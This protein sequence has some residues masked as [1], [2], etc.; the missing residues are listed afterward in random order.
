MLESTKTRQQPTVAC[1]G[2]SVQRRAVLRLA[3]CHE[4]ALKPEYSGYS[5]PEATLK[6]HLNADKSCPLSTN[7]YPPNYSHA[8]D[9]APM[10]RGHKTPVHHSQSQPCR[11]TNRGSPLPHRHR[12]H[13][14]RHALRYNTMVLPPP[15]FCIKAFTKLGGLVNKGEKPILRLLTS[16]KFVR[17]QYKAGTC[18][19]TDCKKA[20]A[21]SSLS[22]SQISS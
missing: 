15:I 2:K 8:G 11:P 3:A 4:P 14:A 10:D 6:K 20:I 19:G 1:L 16:T 12:L 5:I 13:A 7:S 18:G 21:R 17:E 22:A 9:I